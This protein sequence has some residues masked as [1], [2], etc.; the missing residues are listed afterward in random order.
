MT[1]SVTRCIECG[2]LME[3]YSGVTLDGAAYH[4][5]CWDSR[6]RAVPKARLETKPDQA[7]PASGSEGP[8]GG[9][10]TAS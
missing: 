6:V 5:R 4:N 8:S 9:S 1:E 2:H 3:M 7:R 10:H